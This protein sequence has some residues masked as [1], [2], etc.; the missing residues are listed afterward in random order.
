MSQVE[1]S[2]L[3]FPSMNLR[4]PCGTI[5][6]VICGSFLLVHFWPPRANMW[7]NQGPPCGSTWG[8]KIL[9]RV[10][11]SSWESHCQPLCK[12]HHV[13][14]YTRA[15]VLT[16]IHCGFVSLLTCRRYGGGGWGLAPSPVTTTSGTS[17]GRLALTPPKYM[18][19]VSNMGGPHVDC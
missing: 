5:L 6:Q 12:K 3:F 2:I 17:G 18:L 8:R 19:I 16:Y 14:H 9:A 11:Q 7:R 10:E 1:S 15:H 4:V 13:Y